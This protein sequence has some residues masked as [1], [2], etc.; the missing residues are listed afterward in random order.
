MSTGW[1]TTTFR[2]VHLDYHVSN[3]LRNVAGELDAEKLAQAYA[4]A[5]V[6]ALCIFAKDGLG[7][8]MYYTDI[9]RR[10]PHLQRDYLGEFSAALK[11]HGLRVMVYFAPGSDQEAVLRYPEWQ[12]LDEHGKPRGELPAGQM[13]LNSSYTKEVVIPQLREITANYDIDAFFL[14]G[15]FHQWFYEPPCFCPACREGFRRETGGEIPTYDTDPWA[16]RYRLW[17]NARF[18]D[19]QRRLT[20]AVQ[21]IKP[22][23]MLCAN[24]GYSTRFPVQPPDYVGFI[25]MDP[26][27]PSEGSYA[28]HFSI[29]GR[30]LSTV[31]VPFDYMNTR[32][33]SWGDWTLR[34]TIGLQL[35]CGLALANGAR[36]FVSDRPYPN[37]AQEPAVIEAI[38]QTYA[39]VKEREGYCRDAAPVPYVAILHS[40]TSLW[41]RTPLRPWRYWNGGPGMDAVQGAL[42]ALVTS[43]IH[44]NILNSQGLLRNLAAYKVLVLPDQV[45]LS[46]QEVQAIQQFVAGGGGLVASFQTSLKD[47]QNRLNDRPALGD[48]FGVAYQGTSLHL[49][50]YVQ[51]E[52]E[53]LA[54]GN[55]PNLPLQ[56]DA[57][58]ALVAPTTARKVCSLVLPPDEILDEKAGAFWPGTPPPESI[59]EHP[60]LT[61]NR[62]GEGRVA[63]LSSEVFGGYWR[64]DSVNLK[65]LIAR[66]V[67]L[68]LPE[69]GKVI[70]VEAPPS[71]EVSLF[72]QGQN[73]IVH[74]V[75]YHAERRDR[76][77]PN[78]EY[79]PVVNGIKVQLQSAREPQ[80]VLQVPENEELTWEMRDGM[81]TLIVP[82][83]NLH[84]CLVVEYSR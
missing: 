60:A 81:L 20:S 66:C 44:C 47:D 64:T 25:S 45:A 34:P 56:V 71:V 24:F 70:A 6:Q 22:Y 35:E 59:S 76:G 30:Y 58:A 77:T 14:D 50:S 69:G 16:F 17:C 15:T 74:L 63:Y 13:C 49:V 40:A 51:P 46:P 48:V 18:E 55:I 79:V 80:R 36:C 78:I 9:G 7:N 73:R 43:G 52:G 27:T 3:T 54:A 37:G 68:V 31:G 75:N 21:Q 19:I 23:V 42:K 10:H 38:G 62:Y 41:S 33:V 12:R 5:H 26:P 53:I 2:K 8:C 84:S 4:A 67:E 1:Y 72:Q 39:F 65:R 57:P 29:E 82:Q 61:L 11:R 28:V 83:L 32:M